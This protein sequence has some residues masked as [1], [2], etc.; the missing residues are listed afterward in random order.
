MTIFYE[1]KERVS[2]ENK[3]L[4][5]RNKDVRERHVTAGEIYV[6]KHTKILKRFY[7]SFFLEPPW[8]EPTQTA[9]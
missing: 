5:V 1:T 8:Y 4:K 9:A 2:L 6:R 3:S 7:D